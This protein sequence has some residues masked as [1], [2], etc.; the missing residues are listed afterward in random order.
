MN[1]HFR[2]RLS[3]I[4]EHGTRLPL[5]P[6][7]VRGLWR[8]RRTTVHFFLILFFLC[9]PWIRLGGK[10]AFLINLKTGELHLFGLTFWNHDAPLIFFL[11][12]SCVLLLALVTA[13]WGRVWC[14]WACPQTVFLDG[15]IR[16][17]EFW[18]EG[19]H[20]QRRELARAPWGL[21]KAIRKTAKWALFSGLSL[22]LTHSLLA[23][24]WGTENLLNMMVAPPSQ[25]W[26]FFLLAFFMTALLLFDLAWFREQF[27]LI[28]C[29]YGRFQSVLM[30]ADT[31]TVQYDEKR[32]EPRRGQAP[33]GAEGDCVSCN[34]CVQVCPTGIDIRNGIQMECVGCTACVDACD[35][36]MQKIHKPK[37]LIAYRSSS[38]KTFQWFRPR[39]LLYG[40]FLFFCFAGLGFAVMS[41]PSINVTLLKSGDTPFF[42]KTGADGRTSI[43]NNYRMHLHNQTDQNLSLHIERANPEIDADVEI[44]VPEQ[45]TVVKPNEFRMIPFAVEIPKTQMQG[46]S[47]RLLRFK[48]SDQIFEV[49]FVG[50]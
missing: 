7:E 12:F 1:S 35:E 49:H 40:I 10:Q 48:I 20:L 42:E 27:C 38:Q 47:D 3:M 5:F 23:T 8:K 9:L 37:G 18:T 39:I 2:D 44:E 22:L 41:R 43:V 26:D 50:P 25:N 6:A 45:N 21:N 34:R 14:G 36:I 13:L 33:K 29:P 17:I 15:V 46:V 16:R 32:G 28:V 11:L 24:F 30:D 31:V 19:T 4:D